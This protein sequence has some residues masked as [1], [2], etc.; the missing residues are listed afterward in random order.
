[1][2]G[3]V[4]GICARRSVSPKRL[5]EPGPSLVELHEMA[6]ATAAAPDHGR[7]GPARL[8]HIQNERRDALADVF[9]AAALE[10][11]PKSDTARIEDARQ[12]SR[13]GACLIAVIATITE[14]D[15]RVPPHEQWISVGAAIQNVLLTA[16]SFG[17]RAK[18]VSGARVT[19]EAMRSAFALKQ[20]EH[21][22]GFIAVGSYDGEP[23][24]LP[25][26]PVDE[27]LLEWAE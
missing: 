21:L 17:Y 11:E 24:E 10:A 27:V 14:D 22:V 18:I 6:R 15:P 25:R 26:R 3:I 12:R 2:N 9:A 13:N 20:S 7:L 4:D 19:S 8:V 23:K 16:E 1:M 5:I